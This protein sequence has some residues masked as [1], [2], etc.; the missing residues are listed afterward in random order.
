MCLSEIYG[1]FLCSRAFFSLKFQIY[2]ITTHPVTVLL[3]SLLSLC[4]VRNFHLQIMSY[5][6]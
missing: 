1:Y 5:K 2:E 6:I 4:R 3:N